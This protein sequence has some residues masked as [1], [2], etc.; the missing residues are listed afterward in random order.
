MRFFKRFAYLCEGSVLKGKTK[1]NTACPGKGL[2]KG[3]KLGSYRNG[4]G[5]TTT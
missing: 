1:N 2:T 5:A 3:L 4:P